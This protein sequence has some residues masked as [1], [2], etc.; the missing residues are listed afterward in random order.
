MALIG[1]QKTL[2]LENNRE[3]GQDGT[4]GLSPKLLIFRLL[5]LNTACAQIDYAWQVRTNLLTRGP[6]CRTWG[7]SRMELLVFQPKAVSSRS[8]THG[9]TPETKG[10]LEVA[11]FFPRSQ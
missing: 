1:E 8:Q 9:S 7:R 4:R 6:S 3:L 11:L 10:S 5:K 2:R